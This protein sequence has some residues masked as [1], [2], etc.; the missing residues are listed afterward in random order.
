MWVKA[1]EEKYL[2]GRELGQNKRVCFQVVVF[3]WSIICWKRDEQAPDSW[4][5]K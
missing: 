3:R 5:F 2:V 1:K 4:K